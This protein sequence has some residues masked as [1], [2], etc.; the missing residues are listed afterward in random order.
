MAGVDVLAELRAA[1]AA[2]ASWCPR[3]ESNTRPTV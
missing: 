2:S 3:G 1:G